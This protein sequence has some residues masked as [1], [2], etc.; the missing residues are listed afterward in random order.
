M[1]YFGI[2]G[3]RPDDPN[4][5]FGGFGTSKPA[6]MS[7][8]DYAQVVATVAAEVKSRG[9]LLDAARIA[10]VIANRLADPKQTY[11]KT[12]TDIVLS[13]SQFSGTSKK[14]SDAYKIYDA[15]LTAVRTGDMR[16]V[17]R[18]VGLGSRLAAVKSAVDGVYGTGTLRGS[19]KGATHYDNRS[20]TSKRGTAGSHI[21]IANAVEKGQTQKNGS[22]T[23]SR[24][25]GF[26]P[27]MPDLA[28]NPFAGGKA[29]FDNQSRGPFGLGGWQAPGNTPA[30]APYSPANLDFGPDFASPPSQARGP[31]EN[32]YGFSNIDTAAEAAPG[33][34]AG[35]GPNAF[36][37]LDQPVDYGQTY[38][39]LSAGLYP[40]IAPPD[41]PAVPDVMAQFDVPTRMTEQQAIER[42]GLAGQRPSENVDIRPSP[43]GETI[44]EQVAR[45][46]AATEQNDYLAALYGNI[47][48]QP[49]NPASFTTNP[50]EVPTGPMPPERVD[51]GRWGGT[52]PFNDKFANLATPSFQDYENRAPATA[53][54]SPLSDLGIGGI[55]SPGPVGMAKAGGVELQRDISGISSGMY[56]AEGYAAVFDAVRN[57]PTTPSPMTIENFN[58]IFGD[59]PDDSTGSVR[60][61][62]AAPALAAFS[63]AVNA[64]QVGGPYGF[65]SLQSLAPAPDAATIPND[66]T[67]YGAGGA[68]SSRAPSPGFDFAGIVND[69][70]WSG[71]SP[72]VPAAAAQPVEAPPAPAESSSAFNSR[73]SDLLSPG[74]T[75]GMSPFQD[76]PLGIGQG[77]IDQGPYSSPIG[78][79]DKNNSFSPAN[80]GAVSTQA[81]TITGYEPGKTISKEVPNPAWSDWSKDYATRNASQDAWLAA[82]ED[83]FG[84]DRAPP[85][86]TVLANTGWAFRE[87][88]AKTITVTQQTP[89]T[90]IYSNPAVAAPASM[91]AVSAVPAQAP[92]PSAWSP[93]MTQQAQQFSSLMGSIGGYGLQGVPGTFDTGF[94]LAGLGGGGYGGWG[95]GYDPGG[96]GGS[97]GGISPGDAGY[98]SDARS[99]SGNMG[100]GNL[101]Q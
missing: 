66:V 80:L 71:P 57:A 8:E 53:G 93:G 91:P 87:E 15:V 33:S 77:I 21:A 42:A 55:A 27:K 23:G 60:G 100:A 92:L 85:N 84:W 59:M 95:G 96:Y 49:V 41:V 52:T 43:Y 73:M 17:N 37:A 63:P 86:P 26:D 5:Q 48:G 61:S 54:A 65:S 67:G 83:K 46:A 16:G 25:V 88:P 82:D 34:F 44:D 31:V 13:P 9:N 38:P 97:Y 36:G 1:S 30:A 35:Y 99:G 101:Y 39:E 28:P 29:S 12:L 45:N 47:T 18:Q 6:G 24:N 74:V 62:R 79:A 64:A 81:P 50:Y 68:F 11:G 19:A 58:A 76:T 89:P 70:A 3:P 10:D 78:Y 98:G 20:V 40:D 2:G 75:G 14:Q 4:I 94:N 72:N 32:P 51:A 56:P 22:F 90:P 69:T 7:D